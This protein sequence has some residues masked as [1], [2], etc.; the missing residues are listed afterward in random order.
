MIYCEQQFMEVFSY[1]VFFGFMK[2]SKLFNKA[3][4]AFSY[5]AFI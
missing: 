5:A 2:P 3:K 4:G 1:F